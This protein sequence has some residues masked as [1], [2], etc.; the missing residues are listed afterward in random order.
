M[1]GMNYKAEVS[2]SADVVSPGASALIADS[3]ALPA[4]I[5]DLEIYVG[6]ADAAAAGKGLIVE[7]RN[8]ANGATLKQLGGTVA[9]CSDFI[10]ITDYALILNERIRVIAMAQAGA[11][12]SEAF[13]F[14]RCRQKR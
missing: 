2:A 12:N 3:G 9:G 14:I 13:A 1:L 5:Y 7:H 10:T 6:Y 4:G 11:V 8:A